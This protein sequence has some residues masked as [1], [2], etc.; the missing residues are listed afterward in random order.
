MRQ[1]VFLATAIAIILLDV[2]AAFRT[3]ILRDLHA[4][5]AD[6]SWGR[7]QFSIGAAITSL[8]GGYGYTTS[9][10]IKTILA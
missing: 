4:M 3:G 2:F 7:V 1:R 8:D 6:Q 9:D 10:V 5:F